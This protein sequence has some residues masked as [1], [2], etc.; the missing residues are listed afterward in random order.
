M[1]K[2]RQGVPDHDAFSEC[3]PEHL[4]LAQ[5]KP[6]PNSLDVRLVPQQDRAGLL[7]VGLL[8]GTNESLALR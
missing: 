2:E 6:L 3:D 8:F 1:K 7:V 4:V 5:T